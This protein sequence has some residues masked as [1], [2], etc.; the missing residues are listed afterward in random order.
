[1]R[2]RSINLQIMKIKKTAYLVFMCLA[3]MGISNRS[4]AQQEAQFTQY[5]Y[6]T[7]TFNP[8]YAGSKEALNA[9]LI[10]R[11]QW[12]GLEG[13]PTTMALSVNSPI[14]GNLA[15]GISAIADEI[16]PAEDLFITADIAYTIYLNNSLRFAFGV[17]AGLQSLQVDFTELDIFNPTDNQF[18]QNVSNVKPQIGAG[19]Y[20]FM[21][22]WYLGVSVPNILKTEFFDEAAISTAEKRQHFFLIG[23]YVFDVSPTLKLKPATLFRVVSGSPIGLDVSLN[24]LYNERFTLGVS[25]RLSSNFSALAGFQMSKNIMIGY[26]YDFDTTELAQFNSG[27]HELFLRFEIFNKK[28]GRISPRFF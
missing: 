12:V 16:G 3:I 25:Y 14:G 10:Y 2:V 19:G 15:L 13:A 24:A 8:A 1:M 9:N 6:N 18:G 22:N 26:G 27:S 23:G 4:L 20:L 5:M 28:N 7:V 21:D 11:S 17:K